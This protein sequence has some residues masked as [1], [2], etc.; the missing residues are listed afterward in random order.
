MIRYGKTGT[1]AL[2]GEEK[3]PEIILNGES[4]T[5]NDGGTVEEL[6]GDLGIKARLGLIIERNGAVIPRDDYANAIL[7]EADKVELI[8][9]MGGG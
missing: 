9:V 7:K 2:A 8:R 3:M 4:C 5:L 1:R 6:L